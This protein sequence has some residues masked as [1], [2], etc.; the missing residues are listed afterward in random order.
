[1]WCAADS[2]PRAHVRELDLGG[3]ALVVARAALVDV[4]VAFG[5]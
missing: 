5:R 3:G 1:M 4:G 2:N